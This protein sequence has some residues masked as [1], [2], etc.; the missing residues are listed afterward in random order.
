MLRVM[1]WAAYK[2]DL[3]LW[4]AF[5]INSQTIKLK[6]NIINRSN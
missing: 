6:L 2:I 4:V 5:F 1:G 3:I